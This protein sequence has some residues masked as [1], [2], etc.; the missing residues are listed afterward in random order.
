MRVVN[1]FYLDLVLPL[2]SREG[3]AGAGRRTR[4]YAARERR[5]LAENAEEQWLRLRRLCQHAYETTPFYKRRFDEAGISPPRLQAPDD[6]KRLP[7]LTRDDIR[8]HLEEMWSRKYRREDLRSSATGGTTD[9]PVV[10][11]R[12]R[13]SVLEKNA[14]QLRFNQWAGFGPGDKVFYLWGAQQD[15]AQDPSWRWRLF[16][17][18]MMRRVWAHTSYFSDEV[19]ASHLAQMNELRPRVVYAYP[20]PLANFCEYLRERKPDFH[21]PKTVICTAEL[22]DEEQRQ[23]IEATMGCRVFEHYGTR[24]FGMAAGE[25]EAHSGLHMNPAAVYAEYMLVPGADD[26][27]MRELVVTDLLNVGM[28]LIR[29][30][31]NDC[32]FPAE[33]ECA[34]GRGY[35]RVR[36]IVGRVSDNFY[37]TNGDVVSGVVGRR[38]SQAV[39]AVKKL[40]I[41]QDSFDAFRVRF[42]PGP[43]CSPAEQQKM[44]SMLREYVGTNVAI[45]FE[46]VDAIEREKSGKTRLS[47]S[48]VKRPA[49]RVATRG[50]EQG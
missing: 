9:T 40:Q 45:T 21:R 2:V 48:H 49:A 14:S 41:V 8:N 7:L 35:P 28:P 34:C 23:L 12:D 32:V 26:P 30:Q 46:R 10:F 15:Y 27:E 43:N 17:R 18:G 29:Y 42:I 3:F 24:D 16:D 13:E 33:G 19:M 5:S 6:L 37:L 36:S 20:T 39:P 50:A 22:L 25:C 31:V 4:A 1:H 44:E 11:L 38:I 47:I